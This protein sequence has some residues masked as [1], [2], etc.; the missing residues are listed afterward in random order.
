MI[1][2]IQPSVTTEDIWHRVGS[3]DEA[4]HRNDASRLHSVDE[5]IHLSHAKNRGAFKLEF[6]KRDGLYWPSLYVQD[7]ATGAWQ[8]FNQ[9]DDETVAH[10]PYDY[11]NRRL[12]GAFAIAAMV[13]YLRT[14][15]LGVHRQTRNTVLEVINTQRN[16]HGD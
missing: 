7:E 14:M 11:E 8:G 1:R 3:I 5:L 13:S 6:Q 2:R 16:Q 4:V 15:E 10:T 12:G 9:I